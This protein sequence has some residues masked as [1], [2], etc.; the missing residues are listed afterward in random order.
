M[1]ELEKTGSDPG[2][3]VSHGGATYKMCYSNHPSLSEIE[4][5]VKHFAPELVMPLALPA[6]C[7]KDELRDI[8]ASFLV[9]SEDHD[10]SSTDN[11]ENFEVPNANITKQISELR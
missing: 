2:M 7:S 10:S 5:F 1:D 9:S 4:N 6:R 8:L 3:C 11:N